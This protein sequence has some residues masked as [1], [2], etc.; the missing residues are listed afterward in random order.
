MCACECASA[1]VCDMTF[2][3]LCYILV[4]KRKLLVNTAK[5]LV[6]DLNKGKT[7]KI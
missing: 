3:D 7:V 1:C 4:I 5:L 6:L 2:K